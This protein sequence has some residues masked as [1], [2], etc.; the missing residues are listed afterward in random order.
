MYEYCAARGIPV[1]RCGK[2]IVAVEEEEVPRLE[3]IYK[4]GKE[5]GVPGMQWVAGDAI[6]SIEP[7]CRGV[8]AVYTPSTGIVDYKQVGPCPKR[9]KR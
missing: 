4:N 5:N 3:A 7:H 1:K 8:A 9:E 6:A 2:L